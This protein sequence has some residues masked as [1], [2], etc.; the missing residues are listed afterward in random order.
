MASVAHRLAT[1]ADLIAL[2]DAHAEIV[3]GTIVYKA[4]P[5]AEHGDAQAGLV[6]IL[7]QHFHRRSGGGGPG[8]W[9]IL[10]EVDVELAPHEVYRPDLLGW[11]RDRVP[12]RPTGRPVRIR[13]DWVCEVLSISNAATDQVDKFR[14][15]AAS[16]LPFYWIGDPERRILT[17]YRL[18]GSTY[19]VALQA[20]Q[21]EVVRAPPFDAVE[22]RIGLLFG[23]D[24]D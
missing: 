15:Y 24:P 9:W 17:V 23:E 8:G 7:R 21:G 6:T 13:P 22:L 4:D 16:G 10:T 5:S 20:K 1:A 12:E 18:E 2:G 14:I 11:R 19:S 3:G